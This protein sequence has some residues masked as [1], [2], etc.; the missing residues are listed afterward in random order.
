MY[1]SPT[2]YLRKQ[3]MLILFGLIT[4]CLT[5]NQVKAQNQ[6]VSGKVIDLKTKE[7]VSGAWV[8]VIETG[9]ATSTNEKGLFQLLISKPLPI[10]L[11]VY[12][13]GYKEEELKVFNADTVLTVMLEQQHII[14]NEVVVSASRI[15]EHILES[16]VAIERISVQDIAKTASTSFYESLVN[17]KGIEQSTQSFTFK[18]LNTR[19][20][21]A[22]GNVRFNQFV[23]GMDNQAPGLNF[24]VGNIVGI[25]DLD[26]ESAELI[27]GTSSALFGAGGVNGTLLLHSKDPFK[28]QGLSMQFKTGVNHVDKKYAPMTDWNDMQFRYAKAWNNKWAFKTNVSYVKAADWVAH[29]YANYDRTNMQ[30]KE[31][32]RLTDLAYDGVNSYGD[33]IKANMKNVAQAVI[34]SGREAFIAQ[35]KNLTGTNPSQQDIEGFLT[36]DPN[37]SPFYL[38]LQGGAIPDQEVSRTGYK[39]QE[40][41]D[42]TTTSLRTSGALH[43]RINANL[44]A[45]GQAYWGAGSSIY[46]GA[47]R[48]SLMN[49]NLGQYKLEL[50]GDNFFLKGYTTQERSGDAY[51]ATALASLMNE[52]FKPST[53]WFPQYIGN[54][55]AGKNK[56]YN[57]LEAHQA[58]RIQTDAGRFAAGSEEFNDA[59]A[60]IISRAIGP[61]GGAKF[62]DKTNLWHYEGMYNFSGW[63]PQVDLIAGASYRRYALNSGGTIFDDLTRRISISEYGAYMQA[64]KKFFDEKLKAT[65]ALRYDKNENFKGTLSPRIS[66]VWNAAKN[67][68]FRL[69]YQTGFRN[70]TAQAQYLDLLVRANSRLIGALPEIL[71]K[72]QLQTNKPYTDISYR[73][74]VASGYTNPS[75]LEVYPLGKLKP[76]QVEA[77]ELGYKGL[78][79]TDLYIDAYYYFNHYTD[80]LTNTVLWQNP[81]PNNILGMV[82][83][84]RY[85]I[86]V[87]SNQKVKSRGWA[88]GVDYVLKKWK[89]TGNISQD[90]L[91]EIPDEFFNT[92]NTPAYRFNVGVSGNELFKNTGFNLIYRWQDQFVWRSGF[93]V[94]H[95]PAY[96]TLDGQ[97]SLKLPSYQSVLKIGAA[98][99]LNKYYIT[100]LGNPAVG[101][102]YYLSL[103]FD[104]HLWKK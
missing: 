9:R 96:G 4:F 58:A 34:Q 21:N 10:K 93:V 17:L 55:L 85:E 77:Y 51:N 24:S 72:Y 59:R 98:N 63:I 75:L 60:D 92:Y 1:Q 100:S 82:S 87:N 73:S 18:S 36:S 84:V 23:D 101:G 69:S 79:T 42:Y 54:Y 50:K 6:K 97:F 66:G 102:M 61:E 62:K 64:T 12:A 5:F 74:Y 48:Y 38:G 78:L 91:G 56:G 40:L 104:S 90:K 53:Q 94:G 8:K 3:W 41:V 35:Y 22:N 31:G 47:D 20:F 2:L 86:N 25:S 81:T 43:Y 16:P 45:I 88:V 14:G 32:D 89:F 99:M 39:E 95:V 27:S 37:V 49:F 76:E 103:V 28:Y 26:M 33:E 13:I 19:G 44:E 46:T 65:L 15:P 68:Y 7:P 70:P 30:M 67:H 80:F 52:R 11:R 71:D 83:P 29:D 57:D